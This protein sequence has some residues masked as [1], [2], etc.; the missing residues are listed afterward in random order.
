MTL[1]TRW[2]VRTYDVWGNEEHG[3]DVNDSFVTDRDYPIACP[4]KTWNV[5]KP[6]QFSSASPTDAQIREALGLKVDAAIETDGDDMTIY[7]TASSNGYPLGE[8]HC[9][10]HASLSPIRKEEVTPCATI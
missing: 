5:G 10:S 1:N 3:W 4:V 7:V 6:G 9:I 2:E 8:L